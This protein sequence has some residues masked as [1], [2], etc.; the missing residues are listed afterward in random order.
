MGKNGER[1]GKGR[2]RRQRE[3]EREFIFRRRKL[4]VNLC[5]K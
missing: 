4:L 5:E 1:E 2:E 3:G